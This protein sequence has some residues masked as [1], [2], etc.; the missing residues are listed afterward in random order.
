M[1][2]LYQKPKNITIEIWFSSVSQSVGENQQR[3]NCF[4]LLIRTKGL[5]E[6]P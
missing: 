1:A 2:G 6:N 4:R 5:Q 3:A